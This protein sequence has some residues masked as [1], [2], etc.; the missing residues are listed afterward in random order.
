MNKFKEMLSRK[1]PIRSQIQVFYFGRLESAPFDMKELHAPGPR[2][3]KGMLKFKSKQAIKK[4][5]LELDGIDPDK[6]IK[7]TRQ[8]KVDM[9]FADPL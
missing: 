8:D 9:L 5:K 7:T 6:P 2:C 3:F 1:K 4:K